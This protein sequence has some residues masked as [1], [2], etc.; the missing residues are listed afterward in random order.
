M[1]CPEQRAW[2]GVLK[3]ALLRVY[4]LKQRSPALFML[5]RLLL[6]VFRWR[7]RQIYRALARAR[8]GCS[9]SVGLR[10]L[11]MIRSR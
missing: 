11:V 7:T 8:I 10:W 1:L 9:I 2:G 3:P 4:G 5:R 6:V